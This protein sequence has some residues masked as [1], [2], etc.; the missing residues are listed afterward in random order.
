[1]NRD[2]WATLATTY[3]LDPWNKIHNN[4]DY[5]ISVASL[6]K[7]QK[8]N[9][10]WPASEVGHTGF[11]FISDIAGTLQGEVAENIQQYPS[12]ISD[13]TFSK[14]C[15]YPKS[16]YSYLLPIPIERGLNFI[17]WDSVS[18]INYLL[19]VNHVG[20]P[21]FRLILNTDDYAVYNLQM[22]INSDT[23]YVPGLSHHPVPQFLYNTNA[24]YPNISV[25]TKKGTPPS[26]FICSMVKCVS[27]YHSHI[28][29]FFQLD[30]NKVSLHRTLLT[31][32]PTSD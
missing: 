26:L 16:T 25:M 12:M 2:E 5:K 3:Q 10:C 28:E 11:L 17:G 24:F 13:R 18:K 23:Q 4:S 29:P 19:P 27:H 31:V 9:V 1:M 30:P 20:Y 14:P 15:D 7:G 21:T 32:V 22:N 6:P 8:G